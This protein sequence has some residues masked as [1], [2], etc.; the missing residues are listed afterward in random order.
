MKKLFGC[1]ALSF[2]LL[3]VAISPVSMW[4]QANATGSITGQI[5]DQSGGAIAGAQ[6]TLTDV[7]TKTPQQQP[8]NDVGRFAFL[9]LPVGTYDVI[10]TKVGFRSLTAAG[11][12][13]SLSKTLTLNLTLE[14]GITTQTVEIKATP[15]AELQT[16]SSTMSAS[17]NNVTMLDLPSINRDVRPS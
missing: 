9:N 5:T 3:A 2:F 8:T 1:A 7:A 10:I 17:M 16:L 14:V 6:V 4:A 11:Q 15:G 13:V 12:I